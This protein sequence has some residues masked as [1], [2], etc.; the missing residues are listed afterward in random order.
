MDTVRI[1]NGMTNAT[2]GD[3]LGGFGDLLG[4]LGVVDL[5]G[6]HLLVTEDS[7]KGM[8]VQVAGGIVYVPNSNFDELNSDTP[9]FY[10]VVSSA[11]ALTID[12]NVSGDTRYDIVCVKID[13]TISPDPDAD[14][15][16][17]K[18]VIKGTSGGGVPATPANHYKLAE[19]RVVNGAT[20]IENSMITDKR[21]QIRIGG[22]VSS[23]QIDCSGGT[24]TTYG[25][26][27]GSIN[28]TNKVFTVSRGKYTSGKLKVSRN[29]QGLTQGTA[30][31]WVETNP[32]SGTFTFNEAPISGDVILA[33]YC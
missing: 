15:I 4:N 20:E 6:G 24:S 9:R 2:E 8:T 13:K 23:L 19:I 31:E 32:S 5:S 29:G 33:E 14:N 18:V 30:E 10:P 27:T 28:G 7:P 21:E 1:R 22:E 25:V 11:E 3:I 16:A 17:T 12:N 26:L